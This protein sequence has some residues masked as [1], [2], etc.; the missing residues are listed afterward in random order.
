MMNTAANYAQAKIGAHPTAAS[1]Q[2]QQRTRDEQMMACVWLGKEK[3]E[4][5]EVPVPD[6][7]DPEDAI[8]RITGT[9]VCGSDLHLYHGEI[10]Q[11]KSG[12]ILGHEMMGIVE[13]VGDRVTA[14][15][16]GDRVVASFNI[17]CGRC[18]YC[19]KKEYTACDATNDSS[20]QE[21]L[22]GQRI[23]GILG[24]SH[25]VGGFAGKNFS[26]MIAKFTILM[27]LFLY[28]RSG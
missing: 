25:F 23:A 5:R 6:V 9:T 17:A 14:V 7:T 4:M 15:K 11:L 20:L 27:T 24:Y 16:P 26:S 22:Y 2:D 13:K 12:D 18:E 19:R 8:I 28:R 10:M 21:K 3:V 1:N